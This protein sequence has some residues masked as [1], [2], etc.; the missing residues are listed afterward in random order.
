MMTLIAIVHVI[1]AIVLVILVLIQDSKSD[2]ALGIGGGGGGN[3][4]SILGATGAQT[5]AAKLTVAAAI[6]FAVTCMSLTYMSSQANKSVVDTLPLPTAPKA[7]VPTASPNQPIEGT[8][9][10]AASAPAGA[11]AAATAPAASPAPVTK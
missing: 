9:A 7:P 11:P 5:L 8:A 3:S 2:G 1:V 4:N 6:I 10:G